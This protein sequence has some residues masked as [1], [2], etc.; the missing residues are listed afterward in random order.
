MTQMLLG[1][2][3]PLPAHTSRSDQLA[4]LS[5]NHSITGHLKPQ[6]RGY[7][8]LNWEETQAADGLLTLLTE[9]K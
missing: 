8:G 7:S 3:V 9:S 4:S 1:P 5:V 6:P 2:P